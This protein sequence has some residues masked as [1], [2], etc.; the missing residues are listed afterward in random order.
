MEKESSYIG[1][2]FDAAVIA[3][4]W[5]AQLTVGSRQIFVGRYQ[6]EYEAAFFRD[7]AAMREQ[8]YRA[9]LNFASSP[10]VYKNI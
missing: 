4:P 9:K 2:Y 8:G 3:K 1:V 5:K 10:D 6:T 7:L